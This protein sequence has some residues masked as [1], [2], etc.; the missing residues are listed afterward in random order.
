LQVTLSTPTEPDSESV[1][2]ITP[3]TRAALII[4]GMMFAGLALGTF[5]VGKEAAR[6][7]RAREQTALAN[8]RLNGEMVWIPAGKLTMGANDGAPD[9]QPLHDVKISGFWIDQTEVTNQQFTRFIEATSYVTR[10]EK[11]G[12][13]ANGEESPAGSMV[14]SPTGRIGS[15][16]DPAGWW[17]FTPG[18]NWRHPE[19]PGSTLSGRQSHPVVHVA[20]EDAVAYSRWA[21]KRLP[22]EAE[23]EY[24]ARGGLNHQPYVWGRE[25]VPDGRWM[26]NIWQGLF[27]QENRGEDGFAGLA[28]VGSFPPNGFG[29]RD[30]AGNAAE[31][32]AD[33]Y[34]ADYYT[35]GR[36][37]DPRGPEPSGDPAGAEAAQRV[38]RGGSYLCSD[39][40]RTGYRP[41]ARMKQHA[42][43]PNGEIGFRCARTGAPPT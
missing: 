38:V 24:A 17:R 23:W 2:S 3:A 1:F 5:W 14:F 16:T 32:V 30:V 36:Q 35:R 13:G 28:P 20:W 41:S 26:A 11:P 42:R 37:V 31:W 8:S 43:V 6:I 9:E 33:I 22:T 29:L 25:K 12:S 34:R 18:A 27:P 10:A 21:G 4:G 7:K 40:Y 19:G 15:N 39:S